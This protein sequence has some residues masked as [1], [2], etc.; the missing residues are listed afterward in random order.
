MYR[1]NRMF[2]KVEKSGK[3]SLEVPEQRR[4]AGWSST[5]VAASRLWEAVDPQL[6]VSDGGE[7]YCSYAR[8]RSRMTVDH[9]GFFGL[10]WQFL[11]FGN[12]GSFGLVHGS[13]SVGL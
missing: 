4:L 1:K 7:K 8:R 3:V 9:F 2:Q 5:K 12:A 13:M 10:F 11:I 6:Q